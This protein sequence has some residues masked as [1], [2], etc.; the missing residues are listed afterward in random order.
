M[1]KDYSYR[2]QVL[3]RVAC[4]WVLL[5]LALY[6]GKQSIAIPNCSDRLQ[7]PNAR[8]FLR[9]QALEDFLHKV[10]AAAKEELGQPM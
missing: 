10:F 7:R 6:L 1:Y 5:P 2:S 9:I 8:T 4:P 3:A